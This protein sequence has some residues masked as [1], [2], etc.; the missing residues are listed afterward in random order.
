MLGEILLRVFLFTVFFPL[1]TYCNV[2][3]VSSAVWALELL[4]CSI[5]VLVSTLIHAL[6]GC[7]VETAKV[8]PQR[9]HTQRR[10]RNEDAVTDADDVELPVI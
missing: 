3:K 1:A 8:F 7:L 10:F 5:A 6:G 4:A 9:L 2:S